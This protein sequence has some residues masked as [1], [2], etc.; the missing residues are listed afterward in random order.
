MTQLTPKQ[1]EL[2]HMQSGRARS[3]YQVIMY[4]NKGKYL[5][6]AGGRPQ[7]FRSLKKAQKVFAEELQ[8]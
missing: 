6:D 7:W 2:G 5:V 1:F 4:L 8:R 3:G